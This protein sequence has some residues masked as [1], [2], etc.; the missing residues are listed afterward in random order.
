MPA[1]KLKESPFIKFMVTDAPGFEKF[2]EKNLPIIIE[3]LNDIHI[4]LTVNEGELSLFIPASYYNEYHKRNAG[5]RRKVMSKTGQYESYEIN[6]RKKTFYSGEKLTYADMLTLL[7][8]HSDASLIKELNIPRA[9]YYRHKKVMLDSKYYA[10]L[11]QK[12]LTGEAG[13]DDSADEYF[14]SLPGWDNAF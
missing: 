4:N 12:Y 9:T 10:S 14:R 7:Q 5:R 1:K 6:G 3:A 8:T 11:D 2:N 13:P